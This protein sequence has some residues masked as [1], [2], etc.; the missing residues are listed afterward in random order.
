MNYD[1]KKSKSYKPSFKIAIIIIIILTVIGAIVAPIAV[2]W[3]LNNPPIKSAPKLGNCDWL[4]FWGG[5]LG[6]IV[7]MI[8]TIIALVITILQNKDQH[9]QT[10]NEL[11]E[12]NRLNVLPVIEWKD[13]VIDPFASP[14]S[15][16]R[17]DM[18]ITVLEH[19]V[20]YRMVTSYEDGI[21]NQIYKS[22]LVR[23]AC[24]NVGLGTAIGC[25]LVLENDNHEGTI[26]S[27]RPGET[28]YIYF[29]FEY[30]KECNFDIHFRDIQGQEYLQTYSISSIESSVSLSK[31]SLPQLCKIHD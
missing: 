19:D 25:Y 20:E 11:N 27:L 4:A 18:L 8:G 12:T 7:G 15:H 2:N 17:Q 21:R 29:D 1:P 14:N 10:R 9:E 28:K 16:N 6:G 5:Y 30:Q 3:G 22:S 26:D 23:I 24:K 31:L 13:E